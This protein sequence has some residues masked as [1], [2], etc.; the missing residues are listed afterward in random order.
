MVRAGQGGYSEVEGWIGML[1]GWLKYQYPAPL[2]EDHP[3]TSR[4][5]R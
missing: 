4:A 2:P 5:A 1:S 3:A